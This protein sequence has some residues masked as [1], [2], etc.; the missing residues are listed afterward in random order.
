MASRI[1]QS[2]IANRNTQI[3]VCCS[4]IALATIGAFTCPFA[5]AAG[6][7]DASIYSGTGILM[8]GTYS[9][10]QSD[11]SL[12]NVIDKNGQE[13]LTSDISDGMIS[14]GVSGMSRNTVVDANDHQS[15]Q[16]VSSKQSL[17][18]GVMAWTTVDTQSSRQVSNPIINLSGNATNDSPVDIVIGQRPYEEKTH[19]EKSISGGPGRLDTETAVE[20]GSNE[21]AD[22]SMIN[23]K[24]MGIG[25]FKSA[26]N[27]ESKVGFV[28]DSSDV[29]YKTMISDKALV[30]GTKELGYN[31]TSNTTL[32][33]FQ[34]AFMNPAINVSN[35]A[36]A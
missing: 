30:M 35:G 11:G 36:A 20:Q 33:S 14:T 7:S 34:D 9:S 16:S 10:A 32:E 6:F 18:S 29:N 13:R 24:A 15:Y 21:T 23:A 17:N 5:Q 25:L 27:V 19:I 22:Y 12:N 26:V 3:G 28:S 8:V 31:A 4:L 1:L 2:A